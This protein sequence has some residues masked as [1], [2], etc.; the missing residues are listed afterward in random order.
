MVTKPAQIDFWHPLPTKERYSKHSFT[1][2]FKIF[3]NAFECSERSRI[4]CKRIWLLAFL[5]MTLQPIG[6]LRLV[7]KGRHCLAG[8][9]HFSEGG[10][11][12]KDTTL[13]MAISVVMEIRE[14]SRRKE[15]DITWKSCHFSKSV[16]TPLATL[17]SHSNKSGTQL[18]NFSDRPWK[19]RHRNSLPYRPPQRS[20]QDNSWVGLA[21]GQPSS[22]DE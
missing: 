20:L 16:P 3:P 1:L 17:Q 15:N 13:C 14:L 2:T 21:E 4:F 10:N 12:E 18:S 11:I 19:E 8:S 9:V 22:A 7:K 5:W 6:V